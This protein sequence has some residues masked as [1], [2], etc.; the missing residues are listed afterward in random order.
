MEEQ[1][2]L[3]WPLLA[4]GDLH[5]LVVASSIAVDNLRH[6]GAASV[7]SLRCRLWLT[8]ANEP[9]AFFSL[10]TRAWEL[11]LGGLIALGEP[12]LSASLP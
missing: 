3:V 1:F 11:G 7:G 6:P 5:R 10:P 2:Y 12:E 4:R 9:V 8:H